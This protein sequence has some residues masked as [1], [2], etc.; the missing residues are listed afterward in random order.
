MDRIATLRSRMAAALPAEVRLKMA[1]SDILVN[2][3]LSDMRGMKN[4]LNKALRKEFQR[5][6][7]DAEEVDFFKLIDTAVRSRVR[8]NDEKYDDLFQEVS[9]NFLDRQKGELSRSWIPAAKRKID[10]GEMTN[11]YGFL[12]R[13]A[14]NLAKDLHRK[15]STQWSRELGVGDGSDDDGGGGLDLERHDT[16]TSGDPSSSTYARQVYESLVKNFKWGKSKQILDILIE[17]GITGF[18]GRGRSRGGGVKTIAEEMGVTI[19]TVSS[20]YRQKFQEDVVRAIRA[21]RDPDLEEAAMKMLASS[22]AHP[23]V[24]M[25]FLL[26]RV[27]GRDD[28]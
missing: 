26:D 19:V 16:G 20:Y 22:D 4:G 7:I 6:D 23:M 17:H 9:M 27:Q 21:M 10:K 3:G 12:L 24:R 1:L 28:G 15:L 11:L 5:A 25:C 13:M 18:I 14:Q 8:P 2:A